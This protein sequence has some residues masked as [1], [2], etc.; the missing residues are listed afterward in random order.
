M[1]CPRCAAQ[2]LDDAK[3]CRA[4]GAD[5]RLVPQAL[6]GYL[7]DAEGGQGHAVE[8]KEKKREPPTIE[9]GLKNIFKGVGLLCVFLMGL[10]VMRGMWLV[11]I[12]FIIPALASIGEGVGQLVAA[13]REA[14]H[15]LA[16]PTTLLISDT[17]RP[18]VTVLGE[19]GTRETA[20][21][22]QPVSVT[23]TTT[24]ELKSER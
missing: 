15:T 20:E 6:T 18:P 17:P 19:L 9:N 3:Y 5:I 22:S 24:R 8:K 12:W 13:R 16:P 21:M 11:T 14:K 10:F 4:C 7:P 2:N 23:E 1:F